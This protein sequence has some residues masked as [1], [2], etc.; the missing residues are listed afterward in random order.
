M[1]NSVYWRH[2][3]AWNTHAIKMKAYGAHEAASQNLSP[4]VKDFVV[5][6]STDLDSVA[7]D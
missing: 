2:V 6:F 3:G 1:V 7:L 5:V 4:G